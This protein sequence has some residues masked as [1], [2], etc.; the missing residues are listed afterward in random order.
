MAQVF[1]TLSSYLTTLRRIV[2]DSNDI[3]WSA[4]DKTAYLN[5][6]M[7]QRDRD[8]GINRALASFTMTSTVSMYALSS[9]NSNSYDVLAVAL[10]N[11]NLRVQLEQRPYSEMQI[12]YQTI[13]AYQQQPV[14]F[15]KYGVTS[16]I[17]APVPDQNYSTEWDCLVTSPTLV[18]D[19]DQ[20][21]IPYPWT[22]PVPY[23]AAHFAKLTLQQNDEAQ[24]FLQLY[25]SRMT[26][27]MDAARGQLISRPYHTIESSWP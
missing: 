9:A 8:T 10:F 11:G 22:D 25:Q 4:S 20:D 6:A 1:S 12:R 14:C 24:Q 15:A 2:K 26:A 3:Y 16:L 17:F 23:L 27:I 21:P 18:N 19:T 13:N 7:V 5:Q